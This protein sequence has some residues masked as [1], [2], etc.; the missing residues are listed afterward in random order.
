[1]VVRVAR[2]RVRVRHR[3]GRGRVAVFGAAATVRAGRR[4]IARRVLRVVVALRAVDRAVDNHT[5]L[6]TSTPRVLIV[7]AL[8]IVV[9]VHVVVAVTEHTCAADLAAALGAVLHRVVERRERRR[10]LVLVVIRTLAPLPEHLIERVL[11]NKE[12]EIGG[13]KELNRHEPC[14]N[15]KRG[16]RQGHHPVDQVT[17]VSPIRGLRIMVVAVKPTVLATA[18]VGRIRKRT[19]DPDRAHGKLEEQFALH[20]KDHTQERA[21]AHHV[22]RRQEDVVA[23]VDEASEESHDNHEDHT[24]PGGENDRFVRPEVVHRENGHDRGRQRHET[25]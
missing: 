21:P 5:G 25:D 10:R 8:L 12:E 24:A 16:I 3:S 9:F 19:T 2:K 17:R 15:T 1:M 14:L 7:V 18:E 13:E 20:E 6:E 22:G 23:K 4:A 11:V